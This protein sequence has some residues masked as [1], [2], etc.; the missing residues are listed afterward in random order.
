M[1]NNDEK[2]IEII[3]KHS[4]NFL[5]K[6]REVLCYEANLKKIKAMVLYRLNHLDKFDEIYTLLT[7]SYEIFDRHNI[8]HG[9]AVI[10]Y[11]KAFFLFNK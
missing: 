6:K 7:E 9:I 10:S 11:I 8:P 2:I 1:N 4:I 3:E 5:P